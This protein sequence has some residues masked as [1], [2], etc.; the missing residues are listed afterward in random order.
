MENATWGYC[1]VRYPAPAL[2]VSQMCPNEAGANRSIADLE[3]NQEN[4]DTR[5]FRFSPGGAP[6]PYEL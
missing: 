2:V 3:L 1:D 5:L 6:S 4:M